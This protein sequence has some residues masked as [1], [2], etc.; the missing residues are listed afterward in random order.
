MKGPEKSMRLVTYLPAKA[1]KSSCY[2]SVLG[3]AAG[4]AKANIDRWADQMGLPALTDDA[5]EKLDRK[6]ILG[7]PAVFCAL[8]GTFGGMGGGEKQAGWVMLGMVLE[9]G[10]D[11]VFVKMT[12]PVDEIAGEK[13]QFPRVLRV[14]P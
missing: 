8:E 9:R 7:K 13:A 3:G 14:V 5:F 2:V 11:V 1:P 4:G 10:D 12:G 6:T